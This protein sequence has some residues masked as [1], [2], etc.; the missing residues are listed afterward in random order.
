M[1]EQLKAQLNEIFDAVFVYSPVEFSFAGQRIAVPEA[2]Q[3]AAVPGMAPPPPLVAALLGQFYQYCYS[4]KFEIPLRMDGAAPDPA[5]TLPQALSSANMTRER[6]DYGWKV[7]QVNPTGGVFA[8][9]GTQTRMFWPGEFM[10]FEN[11][12]IPAQA[13]AWARVFLA[14]EDVRTQPGFY[15]VHSEIAPSFED[16]ASFVRF[17][18]NIEPEASPALV[19]AVSERFNRLSVPFQFKTLRSRASYAR[20]DGAVLYVGRRYYG[21]AARLAAEVYGIVKDHLRSDVPLFSKRLAPGVSLAEDPSNGESFG[22]ARCRLMGE[23]VW[24]AYQK[25]LQSDRARMA[26]LATAFEANG[27]NADLPHLSFSSVD[28]YHSEEGFESL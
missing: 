16:Q 21:V 15:V 13:G 20:S 23:S 17:Y 1:D 3:A 14:K 7:Y 10:L 28:L 5:D 18:W 22:T 26:E 9:K 11:P 8:Q 19:R 6:W 25:H 12:G 24:N 27:W 2:P 4:K